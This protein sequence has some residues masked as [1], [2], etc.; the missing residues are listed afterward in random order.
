MRVTKEGR[1][2]MDPVSDLGTCNN[3]NP[4]SMASI[5]NKAASAY[6][7]KKIVGQ[8]HGPT[9]THYILCRSSMGPRTIL[10]SPL[11]TYLISFGVHTGEKYRAV[12]K[13]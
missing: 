9:G 6:T 13:M 1:L 2:E 7:V 3:E 12:I 11:I 5:E 8:K 10:S 4:S